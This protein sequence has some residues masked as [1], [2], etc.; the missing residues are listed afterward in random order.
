MSTP[1]DDSL[2]RIE[3]DVLAERL[4]ARVVIRWAIRKVYDGL[5]VRAV[6]RLYRVMERWCEDPNLLTED[7]FKGNEGRTPRHKMMLQAFKNKS[8][9]VRL[10]GFS[11]SV[12]NT[13]TFIIVD[14]DVAKKQNKADPTIL[15]RAKSRVDDF[16]DRYTKK[17]I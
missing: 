6:A 17:E 3:C 14:A 11:S 1:K 16:L 12:A 7:V 10:Y 9:K 15:K 4:G 5:D 13:K 8:A 2:D